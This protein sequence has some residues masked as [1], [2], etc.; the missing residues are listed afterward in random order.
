MAQAKARYLILARRLPSPFASRSS[1][2]M[3]ALRRQCALLAIAVAGVDS[4]RV[5]GHRDDA[6]RH[7]HMIV[8]A[9]EKLAFCYVQKVA[10]EHFGPMFNAVNNITD[11]GYDP[12]FSTTQSLNIDPSQVTRENGWRFAMFVRSPLE[13]YLSAFLSKCVPTGTNKEPSQGGKWCFGKTRSAPVTMEEKVELFEERVR[14]DSVA[15]LA[16]NDH[17]L[18]QYTVMKQNCGVENFAP[19]KLDYLGHMSSDA[20][21]VNSQVKE[22]LTKFTTLSNAAFVATEHFPTATKKLGLLQCPTAHCTQA[23]NQLKHF[24]RKPE[25]V[26][27]VKTLFADDFENFKFGLP[28]ELTQ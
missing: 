4:I 12:G 6:A 23:R 28:E 7:R 2:R 8:M 14:N 1:G 18:S 11:G 27:L 17:W 15:G 25:T 3:G 22:M 20:D 24:Y 10:S 5:S 9:S 26:D 19:E 13:R 21:A 16:N